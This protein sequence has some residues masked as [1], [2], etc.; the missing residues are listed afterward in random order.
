MMNK[1]QLDAIKE[2]VEKATPGE[3][4][5]DYGGV[6]TTHKDFQKVSGGVYGEHNTI[7]NT[8]DGEYI[9]NSNAI[10]DSRFIAHARQDVPALIA[11]VERLQQFEQ[12]AIYVIEENKRL[13]EAL[14][15]YADEQKYTLA[16]DSNLVGTV[17]ISK[18]NG[19]KARQA[20]G[21]GDE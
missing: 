16:Y 14:K 5:G 7:C 10:H 21:D 6:E 8:F 3:W 13:R 15:F 19:K 20:L 4:I 11:E 18:D 1:E 12:K 9:E 17:E 2:R